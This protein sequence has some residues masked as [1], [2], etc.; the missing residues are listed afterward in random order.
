M[1]ESF[2]VTGTVAFGTNGQVYPWTGSNRFVSKISMPN[3]D[4]S[5]L[6]NVLNEQGETHILSNPKLTVLNGQPAIISIGKVRKY[7]SSIEDDYDGDSNEHNYTVETDSIVEGV[8]MGVIATITD[9]HSMIMQLTPVTTELE[10][11]DI[12][13]RTVGLNAAE[14]GLPVITMRELSTTVLLRSEERRVGKECRSR[15]SPYH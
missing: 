5:V 10:G 14:I 13:Y 8:S 1:L 15:W 9:D 2:K 4:F 12:P 11:D 7:I 3:A 6:I